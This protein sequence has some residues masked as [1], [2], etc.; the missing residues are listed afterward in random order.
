MTKGMSAVPHRDPRG[1]RRPVGWYRAAVLEPRYHQLHA[2]LVAEGKPMSG[3]CGGYVYS[4][5]NG[6]LHWHRYVVPKDPRTPA[7][8]RSR[9]AFG[10]GSKA[11]SE[12]QPLTEEQRDA[13]YTEAAKIKCSPR[14]GLSGFL[15]AQQ[16][17]V[18]SNCLKQRWGLPLLLEPPKRERKKTERRKQNTEFSAQVQQPQRVVRPTWEPRRACAAPA[19]SLRG[20]AK[21]R[22]GRPTALRVPI[23]VTHYQALT[24]PSSERPHTPSVPLPV[25]RQCQALSARRADSISLHQR[26]STLAQIRRNARFRELWRGG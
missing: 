14:L 13:W 16:Y 4:W 3:R 6:R 7:Q 20:A 1:R 19:P 25:H 12:N 23:Q 21:G 22:T 18:G 17:F 26:S 2:Q 11:W 15:T 10:T 9:A 5:Y 24:R 8:R